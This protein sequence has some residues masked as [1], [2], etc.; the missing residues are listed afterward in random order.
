MK[1]IINISIIFI[2]L[3]SATIFY[4]ILNIDNKYDMVAYVYV[5][6]ELVETINLHEITEGQFFTITTENDEIILYAE[7]NKIKVAEVDCP[8]E[9][10]KHEGFISLETEL[11]TCVPNKMVV[12]L[13]RVKQ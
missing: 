11:I 12:Q 2:L 10:C 3:I 5:D 4:F 8:K 9:I 13:K 7:Y 6:N 1:K